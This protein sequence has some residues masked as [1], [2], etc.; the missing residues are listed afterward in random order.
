MA[1]KSLKQKDVVKNFKAIKRV[2]K[3]SAEPLLRAVGDEA[4][5]EKIA[6]DR[7]KQKEGVLKKDAALQEKL[8]NK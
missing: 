6:E 8:Q 4:L 5:A 7:R 1:Y 3:K 2:S